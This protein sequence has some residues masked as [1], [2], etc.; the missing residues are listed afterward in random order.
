MNTFSD[1]QAFAAADSGAPAHAA[2]RARDR[3]AIHGLRLFARHGVHEEEARLGQRFSLDLV[4][5]L[6]TRPAGR[7]DALEQAV[8]YGAMVAVAEAAFAERK[9]LIEAA[10]EGV[11]MALLRAFPALA[12]VEVA[13]RKPAAPV[14]AIFEHAEVR[15]L[16]VRQD[17]AE[18]EGLGPDNAGESA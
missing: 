14:E 8:D 11:A 17:L 9:A 16:R 3:V 7:S 12:A 1:P 5:H 2:P 15:I 18:F 6:D 4:A 10:A 13:V